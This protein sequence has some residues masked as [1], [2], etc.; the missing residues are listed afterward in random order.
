MGGVKRKNSDN[1]TG[2][3]KKVKNAHIRDSQSAKV[4]FQNSI[5]CDF[6]TNSAIL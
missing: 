3:N 1:V 4:D 6:S 5:F 2:A